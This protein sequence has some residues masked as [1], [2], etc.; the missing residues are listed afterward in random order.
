MNRRFLDNDYL[1]LLIRLIVG[2]IFIYASLDKI[3]NPAQFARIVYNYH[4]LPAT[5]INIFALMLPWVELLCGIFLVVGYKQEGSVLILNLLVL[6]FIAALTVNLFRGVNIECG[7]FTVSSKAKSNIIDLL[8]RDIGLLALTLYL[9]FSR[10]RR[11]A[12]SPSDKQIRV[13]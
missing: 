5:L 10:S 13:S 2:G 3:T 1:T 7:C 11:F 12:L 4:L 9:F 6:A 8:L